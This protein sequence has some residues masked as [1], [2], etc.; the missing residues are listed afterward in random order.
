M[1]YENQAILHGHN[2]LHQ[3]GAETALTNDRSY[4]EQWY[5]AY[6]EARR[7]NVAL[8]NL[9]RQGFEAY[10]PLYKVQKKRASAT[11][12]PREQFSHEPMFPRYMF[13][14]P[15]SFKQSISTVRSTR[16]VSAVVR[17]GNSFAQ[18]APAV[19]AAIR[20]HEITRDQTDLTRAHRLQPGS[21]IKIC[22]P[23]LA[24]LEGLVHSV[25]AQ[26]VI[27]LMEILGRQ[28]RLK[29]NADA[30]EPI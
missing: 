30:V 22:N 29:L 16:G 27:V 5:V 25:S 28:T 6:T 2:K 11:E 12:A 24:G 18:V 21:R 14:R 20:E 7:E 17:F 15:A 10:L 9:E 19:I 26:R 4:P 1:L 13:F 8:L 3:A 23:A